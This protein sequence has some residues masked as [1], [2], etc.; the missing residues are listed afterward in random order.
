MRCFACCLL[1]AFSGETTPP[2]K[3]KSI[4]CRPGVNRVP[5]LNITSNYA[6]CGEP[7]QALAGSHNSRLCLAP[8]AC[9]L[10][11]VAA[12]VYAGATR[13]PCTPSCAVARAAPPRW[14]SIPWPAL[15]VAF[16]RLQPLRVFRFALDAPRTHPPPRGLPAKQK[17]TLAA[18][19]RLRDKTFPQPLLIACLYS[20]PSRA[21]A[22]KPLTEPA[23]AK[24]KT[25]CLRVCAWARMRL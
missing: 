1:P 5:R 22:L 19:Q 25:V 16:A 17:Q 13:Y 2:A 11:G 7:H 21:D 15:R 6:K 18:G 12:C 20:W 14:F 8:P 9:R 24:E 10:C 23:A 4:G 3:A